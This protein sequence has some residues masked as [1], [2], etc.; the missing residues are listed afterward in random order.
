MPNWKDKGKRRLWARERYKSMMN[1]ARSFKKECKICGYNKCVAALDF[2][3]IDKNKEF[4]ITDVRTYS[5]IKN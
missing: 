3:H 1:Y 4:K 5:K 2:H